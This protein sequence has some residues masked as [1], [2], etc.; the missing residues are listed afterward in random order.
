MIE[1]WKDVVGYEGYYMISNI[2]RV[3]TVSRLKRAKGNGVS[4]VKE[5]IRPPRVD[6]YGYPVITLCV[7]SKPKKFTIHRLVSIAFIPNPDNKPQVNHIDANKFNNS[8]DNLEWVTALEN[9]Q[10]AQK[11]G[12]F[13][14]LYNRKSKNVL[15][16]DLNNNI[17]SVWRS[18]SECGRHGF[19]REIVRDCCLCRRK[20]HKGFK[21]KYV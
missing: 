15:Q 13:N 1:I 3:K 14:D 7:D 12:L 16:M 5:Y 8:V 11:M 10:H 18:A 2:G 9:H 4:P 19:N 17:I 21:W 20:T 6:K